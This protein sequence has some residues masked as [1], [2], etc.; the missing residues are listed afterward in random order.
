MPFTSN[1]ALTGAQPALLSAATITLAGTASVGQTMTFNVPDSR[2]VV[3][4][5]FQKYRVADFAD[6]DLDESATW[7]EAIGGAIRYV[8]GS[9]DPSPQHLFVDA[10]ED[11]DVYARLTPIT[12]FGALGAVL[13]QP[14][15]P[16]G[17]PITGSW[18]TFLSSYVSWESATW[19]PVNSVRRAKLTLE[20]TLPSAGVGYEWGFIR[21]LSTTPDTAYF[22]TLSEMDGTDLETWVPGVEEEW[23]STGGGAAGTTNYLHWGKKRIATS[24]IHIFTVHS[25]TAQETSPWSALR[26]ENTAPTSDSG[27]YSAFN[28]YDI[29]VST[30]ATAKKAFDDRVAAGTTGDYVIGLNNAN[31]GAWSV[32]NWVAKAGQK[33]W[34]Q[35]VNKNT[36]DAA[37]GGMHVGGAKMTSIDLSGSTGVGF[38]FINVDRT[39]LGYIGNIVNMISAQRGSLE[40]CRVMTQPKPAS[41]WSY[42]SYGGVSGGP[43]ADKG[44]RV[45]HVNNVLPTDCTVRFNHFYG[46]C[47]DNVYINAVLR[48]TVEGNVFE[49][50]HADNIKIG[51][52]T[53]I[54]LI[55][56]WG[57][58]DFHHSYNPAKPSDPWSH[59]DFLQCSASTP[60]ANLVARGNVFML[61]SVNDAGGQLPCQGLFSDGTFTPTGWVFE[62][63]III[64]QARNGLQIAGSNG[65][66]NIVRRN[67][68]LRCPDYVYPAQPTVMIW[69]IN[70]ASIVDSNVD[71]RPGG[72]GA[73][74]TNALAINIV[75]S[76]NDYSDVLKYYEAPSR[77][78]TFYAARP[79]VGARTHHLYTGT[80][81]VPGTPTGAAVKFN[82]I[83]AGK[84]GFPRIGPAWASW[85]RQYDF[86]NE[87]MG[88]A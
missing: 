83:I 6:V 58:R 34:F 13:S 66:G 73:W 47:H 78:G 74:G 68:L 63:N 44:V 57:A 37:L 39:G 8:V 80:P 69:T 29:I 7:G 49:Q 19:D 84:T 25:G 26:F 16:V 52:G 12:A 28:T 87:I 82:A 70:G 59:A 53:N 35:S 65:S 31:Y 14:S 88:A 50:T 62:D 75:S 9:G 5:Q 27:D 43:H 22:K 24:E 38:R 54:S 11:S 15:G 51:G 17:P 72:T 3:E 79:K 32:A 71:C 48:L 77:N 42:D 10:D 36:A 30:F 55:E 20:T 41:G 64:S 85:K 56:N 33:I 76:T 86:L 67:T 40:Y 61:R 23:T 1:P 2:G 21:S 18:G 60:V 81:Q 46:F 4:I 45:D